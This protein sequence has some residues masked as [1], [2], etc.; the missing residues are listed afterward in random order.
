MTDLNFI[1][2]SNGQNLY[3]CRQIGVVWLLMTAWLKFESPT[4]P[5]LSTD[6]G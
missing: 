5:R 4:V 3:D 1:G 2:L 6:L